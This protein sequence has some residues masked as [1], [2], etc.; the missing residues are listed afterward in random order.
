MTTR[1]LLL[2]LAA[3]CSSGVA[4]VPS[5]KASAGYQAC[6]EHRYVAQP[7]TSF[8]HRRSSLVVRAGAANHSAQDVLTTDGG[9]VEVAGKFAYGTL[10]KDL[11]DEDVAV[12]LDTCDG[13][14]SVGKART[15]GDGRMR[16]AI[17]RPLAAGTYGV[18][19][20]VVGDGSEAQ[21]TIRVHPRGTRLAVFDIDGTLTTSDGEILENV[22]TGLFEPMLNGS[23]VPQAY[24]GAAALTTAEADRGHVLLY[25]TGRPYWLS[26]HTRAWLAAGGFAAGSVHVTDSHREALM[27]ES[28]VGD[29]KKGYLQRLV[30]EG[31]VLDVAY[32]NAATD[33]YA[34]LGAGLPAEQVT[35]I[36]KHGGERGTRAVS[37]SWVPTAEAVK[38]AP[39]VVQPR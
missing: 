3:S 1:A 34:Y 39:K 8:E 22:V 16:L 21:A 32:G 12:W 27:S 35:I 19:L 11:E 10:S 24:P 7:A 38:Q 17:D 26:A 23:H 25:L 4:P 14:V 18:R 30:A 2:L 5:A 29:F 9:R 28:G 36:G 13:W 37:D 33:V 20:Q 6:E 31:F 15:D